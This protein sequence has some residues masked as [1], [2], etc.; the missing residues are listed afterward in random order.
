[1]KNAGGVSSKQQ[2]RP[3]GRI[4]QECGKSDE[5]RKRKK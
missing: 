5:Q 3:K 4:A 1:M 2:G